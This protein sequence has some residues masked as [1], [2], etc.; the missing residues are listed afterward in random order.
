MLPLI[1]SSSQFV[2]NDC[3]SEKKFLS[4]I[5]NKLILN[6]V[7]SRKAVR[8]VIPLTK[9]FVSIWLKLGQ[10]LWRTFSF[11]ISKYVKTYSTT[12]N[13]MKIKDPSE[14]V[15]TYGCAFERDLSLSNKKHFSKCE[16]GV[17]FSDFFFL[18]LILL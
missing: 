13:N 17:K 14:N 16:K 9:G 18:V 5:T 4:A 8:S 3:V 12:E 15:A 6:G 1:S 11:S 7:K 2:S 10:W